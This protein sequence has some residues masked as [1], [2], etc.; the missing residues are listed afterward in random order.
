MVLVDPEV[1]RRKVEHELDL[2]EANK[3]IY[4]RRGWI[5]LADRD[6]KL[7]IGFL[8]R[9][10]IGSHQVP[11]L[12]AC[13]RLD[14]TNFD[15]WPPS[16]EFIN[17]FSGAFMPPPV[18]ALVDS[19]EGPRDLLVQ[20]HPDTNRPFFCVPGIRQY[21]SHPQHSGDPWA[22]HR[23]TGEG[24]LATICERV[25]RTMARNVLGIHVEFQTLPGRIQV[26]IRVAS[27]P[28]DIAPALWEEAEQAA[29]AQSQ[30]ADAQS[31][32]SGDPSAGGLLLRTSREMPH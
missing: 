5:L 19:E 31:K 15:L 11:A 2:W 28:G 18:Q 27:A 8:A 30:L 9:L 17:P 14:F 1:T 21:H 10:P 13:I 24:T 16:L 4:Q 29:A 25:W 32:L 7:D 26:Q 20:S 12:A 3:E 22:L 23:K 6:L